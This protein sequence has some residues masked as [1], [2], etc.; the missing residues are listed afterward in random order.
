ME[1]N[2]QPHIKWEIFSEIFWIVAYTDKK[3][4]LKRDNEEKISMISRNILN[5]KEELL[6]ELLEKASKKNLNPIDIK[7]EFPEYFL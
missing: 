7:N 2:I 5:K 3:I 4:Y 6:N 1:I